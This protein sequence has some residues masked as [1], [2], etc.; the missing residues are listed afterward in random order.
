MAALISLQDARRALADVMEIVEAK[1]IRN[2]AEALR[3]YARISRD[4]S[5]LVN[6]HEI[7]IRADRRIGE[8]LLEQMRDG[9]LTRGRYPRGWATGDRI[10][11]D[12]LG[13]SSTMSQRLQRLAKLSDAKF[14]RLIERWRELYKDAA[15]FKEI[16]FWRVIGGRTAI[17]EKPRNKTR[18]IFTHFGKQVLSCDASEIR[19]ALDALPAL[20]K[21]Y[22]LLLARLPEKGE[23]RAHIK[24]AEFREILRDGGW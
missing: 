14:N 7:K 16:S 10:T 6:A 1:D 3:A 5:L 13:I 4:K 12:E 8:L 20:E 22:T 18:V 15:W 9:R 21:L 24:N 2:K 19:A 11:L 23:G 17:A